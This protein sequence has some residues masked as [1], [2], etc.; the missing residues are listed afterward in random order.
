MQCNASRLLFASSLLSFSGSI[1]R[2][3]L[4]SRAFE[5]NESKFQLRRSSAGSAVVPSFFKSIP[6]YIGPSCRTPVVSSC[7]LQS[8]RCCD[9]RILSQTA[10]LNI[11]ASLI[12]LMC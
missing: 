4:A 7:A 11:C 9:A 6:P 3:P 1:Q 5:V 2:L 8:D 12:M 10:A